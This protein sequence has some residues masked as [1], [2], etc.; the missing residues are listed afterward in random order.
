MTDDTTHG[1]TDDAP[2][3]SPVRNAGT[4]ATDNAAGAALLVA[5]ASL[6]W[7]KDVSREASVQ[8][9]VQPATSG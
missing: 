2:T 6:D 8:V 3:T 7:R 5:D 4:G 9:R 1:T